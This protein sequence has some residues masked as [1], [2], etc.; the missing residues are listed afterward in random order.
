MWLYDV[1]LKTMSP[2]IGAYHRLEV[3][4]AEKL[5]RVGEGFILAPNHSG[6]FGWDAVIISSTITERGVRWLSWSYEKEHPLWDKT[7]EAFNCIMY[8]NEKPFPYEFVSEEVLKK[9]GVVGIFPEGNS[10]PMGKWYRLRPF[11]PG[12]VRLSVM[13]GVPLVPVA[14]AGL[15]EAS[16]IL[17]A[18][19]E[20]REP[21]KTAV[22][23]PV[24]FP[25][26]AIVRF[27]EPVRYDIG[28]EAV[29][30]KEA[31]WAAA[32]K[33]QLEVLK[34]LKQDRPR[35]YAENRHGIRVDV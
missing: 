15:E 1:L 19:E 13:A 25:T 22:A 11:F 30:N 24:V 9:G 35:A 32:G 6:W 26:K 4:G 20:K 23:L 3:H 17:W 16:P 18:K 33:L 2:V 10:N 21:I 34:L 12:C 8:N 7:V 5:P 28:D 27:G 14:V 29:G 31:L